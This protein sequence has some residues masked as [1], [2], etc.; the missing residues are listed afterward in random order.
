MAK[1]E[2]KNSTE[3]TQRNNEAKNE[4]RKLKKI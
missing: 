2:K 4:Q 1:I 3:R